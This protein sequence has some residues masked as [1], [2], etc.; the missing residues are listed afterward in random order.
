M[1]VIHAVDRDMRVIH[2][3]PMVGGGEGGGG[4]AMARQV[5]R[6]QDAPD[7]AS[8]GGG[9]KEVGVSGREGDGGAIFL[10]EDGIGVHVRD[11]S[12]SSAAM[13]VSRAASDSDLIDP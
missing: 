3:Q 2:P 13:W 8:G 5:L 4:H 10:A 7:A 9:G 12:H 6:Q 1:R 11:K